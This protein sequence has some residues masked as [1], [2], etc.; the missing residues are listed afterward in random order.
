M[1]LF[2]RRPTVSA[3]SQRLSSLSQAVPLSAWFDDAIDKVLSLA[4]GRREGNNQIPVPNYRRQVVEGYW[5]VKIR[6]DKLVNSWP[7][8]CKTTGRD[9]LWRCKEC[10]IMSEQ[11][12]CYRLP[13]HPQIETVWPNFACNSCTSRS[14]ICLSS[15]F[16]DRIE[17]TTQLRGSH[18]QSPRYRA[19]RRQ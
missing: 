14:K 18:N 15:I 17:V 5:L 13:N 12:C 4:H 11:V 3:I 16:R 19:I 7:P 10:W 2:A 8:W 1:V 9:W 6:L